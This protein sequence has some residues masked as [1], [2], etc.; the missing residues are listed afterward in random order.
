MATQ[1]SAGNELRANIE[2]LAEALT[3][4]QFQSD[5][6]LTERYGR[7]GRTRCLED[8]RFHIAFLAAAVDANSEALFLDYVGWTKTVLVS[9]RIA[10]AD[11]RKNL[12]LL[13]KVVQRETPAAARIAGPM[14]RRAIDSI[15]AMSSDVPTFIDRESVAG[16]LASAYLSKLLEGDTHGSMAVIAEALMQGPDTPNVCSEVL[17]LA[18][19]EVGRLWQLDEISVATEHYCSGVT[20]QVI[21]QICTPRR[22]AAAGGRLKI[23]TMCAPG[24]LHD[25]GLRIVSE[26]L[27]LEHWEVFHLGA[28][29]PPRAAVDLCVSRKADVLVVSV[30]L[31]PHIAGVAEVVQL[32]R[33]RRELDHMRVIVGGRAF[34]KHPEIVKFTGADGYAETAPELVHLLRSV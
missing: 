27:R 16:A 8:A 20:Q 23:V 14:I 11:L 4:A 30:T 17:Q 5:P 19:Q 3:S 26:F 13:E 31:P 28:N 34:A 22:A 6:A 29:V 10:T 18:Q 1:S 25:I 33:A 21:A 12:E 7:V 32:A 24:E 2:L 15:D 9:R